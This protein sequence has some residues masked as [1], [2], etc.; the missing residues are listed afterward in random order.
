MADLK[1]DPATAK[2]IGALS[3]VVCGNLMAVLHNKGLI[4]RADIAQVIAMTREGG[5]DDD[6]ALT[7][8]GEGLASFLEGWVNA[9]LH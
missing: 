7:A 9:G 2:L 4:D 1:I 6:P 5:I 3:T 8:M